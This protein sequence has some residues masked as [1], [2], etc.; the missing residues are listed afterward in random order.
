[1]AG[2]GCSFDTRSCT[3][4]LLYGVIFL[5]SVFYSAGT[6]CSELI[7]RWYLQRK[8]FQGRQ[9]NGSGI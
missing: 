3:D 4:W 8:L 9:A 6:V 5:R 7:T 1:M 2:V